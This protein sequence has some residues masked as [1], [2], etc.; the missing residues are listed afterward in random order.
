MHTARLSIPLHRQRWWKIMFLHDY[1]LSNSSWESLMNVT[2][3]CWQVSVVQSGS[4]R[5]LQP[6]RC[7]PLP[8][9]W[10]L[11]CLPPLLVTAPSHVGRRPYPCQWLKF[12]LGII[13]TP[14]SRVRI[15]HSHKTLFDAIAKYN[16]I[17]LWAGS[18]D[19]E[20]IEEVIQT[21]GNVDQVFNLI[22]GESRHSLQ[23]IF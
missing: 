13:R 15:M 5:P 2:V 20:K 7:R 10:P 14:R 19:R 16:Q 17:L 23:V 4:S 12:R 8:D 11:Q 6:W 18:F 1:I 21:Q 9:C 3:P 22:P